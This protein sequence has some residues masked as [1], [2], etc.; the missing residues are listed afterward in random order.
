M[1]QTTIKEDEKGAPLDRV[2]RLA[3]EFVWEHS[4]PILRYRMVRDLRFEGD[5]TSDELLSDVLATRAVRTRLHK[6]SLCRRIHGSADA[7]LENPVC[8]LVEFGLDVSVP[9]V[10]EAMNPHLERLTRIEPGEN[11]HGDSVRLLGMPL[12]VAI[13]YADHPVVNREF[14]ARLDEI[15]P[16][17]SEEVYSFY[18]SAAESARVPRAWR[19]KH[20]YKPKYLTD[21]IVRLP[22]IYDFYSTA[23]WVA[24][25][26]RYARKVEAAISYLSDPRFQKTHGGYLWDPEIGRCWAAGEAF[27]AKI[28]EPRK[29]LFLELAARFPSCRKRR[30]F[31]NA[32]SEF[33]STRTKRGTWQFPAKY[34][35]ESVGYHL[36][37]GHHMSLGEDRRDRAWSERESTFRM[38]YLK[39]LMGD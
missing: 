37:S 23:H 30:W 20:I 31:R 22:S 39:K 17:I 27:L 34:L 19:G 15:E 8:K 25:S 7:Y 26:Q 14:K 38:L 11:V 3:A 16:T 18:A 13:G 24:G 4:G 9:I 2:D 29:W 5:L 12:L 33:E 35:N 1:R 10:A 32:L 36:Y 6:L 28:S 21:H